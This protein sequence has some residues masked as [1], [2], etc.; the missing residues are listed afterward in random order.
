MET[1]LAMEV[2]ETITAADTAR[3]LWVIYRQMPPDAKRAFK[4]LLD[5]ETG[6]E[7]NNLTWLPLSE[8]TLNALW[9]APEEDYWDELYA[10]QHGND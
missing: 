7:Y 8:P 1:E 2:A 5:K 6:E 9:D 10:K 3:S 4:E